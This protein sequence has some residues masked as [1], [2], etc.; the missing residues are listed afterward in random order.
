VEEITTHEFVHQYFY[1]ILASDEAEEPWM[2]EGFTTYTTQKI[3]A[4]TYGLHASGSTFLGVDIGAYDFHK[5]SYMRKPDRG[6]VLQPSWEFTRGNYGVN[7]YSKPMLILTTLENILGKE[8][9]NRIMKAYLERWKFKH[10][11]T[12]DFEAIVNQ[13]APDTMD[14]FFQQVLLD[15]CV[16]DYEVTS[17]RNVKQESGKPDKAVYI[18][19]AWIKRN[20]DM[21]IPTEIRCVFNNGDTLIEHWSGQ[22]TL[23]ILSFKKPSPLRSA[24]VDPHQKLWLDLNWTNNSYTV[25]EDRRALYRHALMSLQFYQQLLMAI[26]FF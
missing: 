6:I 24:Q 14:W 15:S 10:P 19:E 22:D 16:L 7:T 2:D 1:G 25:E 12:E 3:L 11:R 23:H 13:L 5:K 20:G 26:F 17:V 9:M 21:I 4:D 8:T 18:S